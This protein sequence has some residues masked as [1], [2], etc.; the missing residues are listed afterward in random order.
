MMLQTLRSAPK[1]RDGC[2]VDLYLRLPYRGEVE[3][4][5]SWLP[6]GASVLE[7]G[8]GVGRVTQRLLARCF[9]VTAID[10]SP[11]M[12]SHVPA[13]ASRLRADIEDLDLGVAFDAVIFASCLIN[14]SDDSVRAMQLTKCRQ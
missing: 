12:L 14:I 11:D 4:I 1:T 13:E 3:L 9:R 8:C 5:S 10:N 6:P 7:L 2:S